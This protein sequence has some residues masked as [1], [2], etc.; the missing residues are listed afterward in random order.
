MLVIAAT[1]QPL[2][3]MRTLASH[4]RVLPWSPPTPTALQ[5]FQGVILAQ[6]DRF[7]QPGALPAPQGGAKP[8]GGAV[9]SPE[10]YLLGLWAH[11]CQ[12]VFADKLVS[13]EDKAWVGG[14]ITELA[15]QV[16][17]AGGA[18]QDPCHTTP[19]AQRWGVHLWGS[20]AA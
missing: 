12:R 13:Q 18:A 19:P 5:V 8:F 15:K 16:G 9:A 7:A 17:G 3:G 10:G 14:T 4:S 11:E 2:L 20:V 1:K 6:R